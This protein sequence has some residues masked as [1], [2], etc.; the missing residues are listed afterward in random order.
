MVQS[1]ELKL[2]VQISTDGVLSLALAFQRLRFR[3]GAFENA[4]NPMASF[5]ADID[6]PVV[7]LFDLSFFT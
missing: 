6:I 7:S 3:S 5:L 1:F 4:L 2:R